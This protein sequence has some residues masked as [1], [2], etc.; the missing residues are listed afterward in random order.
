MAKDVREERARI[1][2]RMGH[3]VRIC[4]SWG[5]RFMGVLMGMRVAILIE[6]GFE[7]AEMVDPQKA[8]DAHRV[9]GTDEFAYGIS[10]NG[11]SIT[12]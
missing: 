3:G 1:V 11:R 10:M 12:V 4:A 5:G 7:Q 6:D 9:R 2:F 8:L